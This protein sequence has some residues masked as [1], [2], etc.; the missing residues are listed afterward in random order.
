ML[1][2][3]GSD[4][5]EVIEVFSAQRVLSNLNQSISD[6]VKPEIKSNTNDISFL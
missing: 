4:A 2:T 1:D 3:E 5:D 6:D